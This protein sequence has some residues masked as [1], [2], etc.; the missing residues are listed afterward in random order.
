MKGV[1]KVTIV[2]ALVSSVIAMF[3][4]VFSA[5]RAYTIRTAVPYVTQTGIAIDFNGEVHLYN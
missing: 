3:V 1:I 5:A 4:G 2:V